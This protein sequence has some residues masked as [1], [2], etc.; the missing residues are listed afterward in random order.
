[1]TGP[2]IIA[3]AAMTAVTRNTLTQGF[4]VRSFHYRLA[5]LCSIR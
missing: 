1:M 4:K 2:S 5:N 3:G